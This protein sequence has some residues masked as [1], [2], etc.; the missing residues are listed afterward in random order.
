MTHLSIFPTSR[1]LNHPQIN[2]TLCFDFRISDNFV[3]HVEGDSPAASLTNL[4]AAL[5][6]S[7]VEHLPLPSSMGGR[8]RFSLVWRGFSV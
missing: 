4:Y 8:V 6:S 3:R 2:F 5:C 1:N 7:L